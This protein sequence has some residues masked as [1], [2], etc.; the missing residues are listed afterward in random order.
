MIKD[1][2]LTEEEDKVTWVLEK[3]GKFS[4]RSMYRLLA[5]GALSTVG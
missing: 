2:T 1:T 4:T 5:Q 3:S